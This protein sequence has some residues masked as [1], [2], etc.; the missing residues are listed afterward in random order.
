[1]PNETRPLNEGL[2]AL[3][4]L[5][6]LLPCVDSQVLNEP[7]VAIERFPTLFAFIGPFSGVDSLVFNQA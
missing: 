4:A 7:R 1:M 2:P 3:A 6:G 5:V